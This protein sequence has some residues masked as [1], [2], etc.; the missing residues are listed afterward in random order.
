MKS[1]ARITIEL[2]S[3]QDIVHVQDVLDYWEIPYKAELIDPRKLKERN[4]QL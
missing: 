3:V 4:E 2:D 1:K